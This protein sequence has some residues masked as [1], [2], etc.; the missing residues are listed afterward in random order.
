MSA[1]VRHR[2]ASPW[3]PSA[4]FAASPPAGARPRRLDALAPRVVR[5]GWTVGLLAVASLLA[6]AC[7][8]APTPSPTVRP[9]PVVTPTP[10]PHL[11]EPASA[12]AV[13]SGLT[14]SGLSISANT[15]GS[16]GPTGEPRKTINATYAGWPLLLSEFSSRAA[17]DRVVGSLQGPLGQ[18]KPPYVFAGLNIL[19]QYGPT[20]QLYSPGAPA[21]QFRIAAAALVSALDRLIGPLRQQA[22]VPLPLPSS[23][24]AVAGSPSASA[25]PS[26]RVSTAP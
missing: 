16:G 2:V 22:V 7:G 10:N 21:E 15:A 17:L 19:I 8:S 18:G 24:A 13:Y 3:S 4:G 20:Q 14:A 11:A 5:A 1:P 26:A 6:T 9:T 23:P 25:P 12:D